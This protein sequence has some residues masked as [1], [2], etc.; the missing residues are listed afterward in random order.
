MP[1]REA[2]TAPETL[3]AY[4]P[5]SVRPQHARGPGR[6]TTTTDLVV[7]PS[8]PSRHAFQLSL[9]GSYTSFQDVANQGLVGGEAMFQIN[10]LK[11]LGLALLYN[12]DQA[13]PDLKRGK[14]ARMLDH[15]VTLGLGISPL[16]PE[17]RVQFQVTAGPAILIRQIR[18]GDAVLSEEDY[19]GLAWVFR[20][21]VSFGPSRWPVVPFVGSNVALLA[22]PDRP[23]EGELILGDWYWTAVAGVRLQLGRL[24]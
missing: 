3:R 12:F 20:G 6:D 18:T 9:A 17:S 24:R 14:T 2:A 22:Q 8:R 13:R 10:F 4:A 11:V 5:F 15:R 16:R 23:A 19:F 21:D 7:T 1:D